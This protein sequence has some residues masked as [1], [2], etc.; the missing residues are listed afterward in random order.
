VT[1]TVTFTPTRTDLLRAGYLG[2]RARPFT[3]FL[4]VGF[5][6]AV[7]WL[8]ALFGLGAR[9]IGARVGLLP[10]VELILIPPVAVAAF[11]LIML[12]GVRGA[13]TLQGTHSYEFSDAGIRLKGPGFDNRVEWS[14]LTRCHA[15]PYGLLFMTGAAPL[16]SVPGRVLSPTSRRAIGDLVVATA[17]KRTGDWGPN[18]ALEPTA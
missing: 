4:S 9:V 18:Q 5:F 1:T 6:I 16:I 17:M 10:V 8:I 11:A 7:P 3:F 15:S 14:A 13:R 12:F 2:L